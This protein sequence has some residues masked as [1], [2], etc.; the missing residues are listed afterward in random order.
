M[1]KITNNLSLTSW[2]IVWFSLLLSDMASPDRIKWFLDI[3]WKWDSTLLF[4][5]IWALGISFIWHY[6]IKKKKK[7]HF[8]DSWYFLWQKKWI[9]DKKLIIWAILFGI[10]WWIWWFCP[11]PA[12]ASIFIFDPYIFSFLLSMLIS[13]MIYKLYF[14]N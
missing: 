1:K 3:Y 9:I 8:A 6:F 7:P 10:G 12:F 5:M 4:V 13:M 2:I 14:S 11:W